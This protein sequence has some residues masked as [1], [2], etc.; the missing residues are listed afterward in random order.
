MTFLE[1]IEFYL[2]DLLLTAFG[3]TL[4]SV[5]FLAFLTITLSMFKMPKDV[6]IISVVSG[7]LLLV[8]F[9]WIPI[10]FVILIAIVFL[11]LTIITINGGIKNG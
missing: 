3:K 10:F 4:I 2:G 7:L 11:L 8:S 6:I 5:I 9:G 1:V